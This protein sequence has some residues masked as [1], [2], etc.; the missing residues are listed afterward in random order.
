MKADKKNTVILVLLAL[1][2]T[3]TIVLAGIFFFRPNTGTA[4]GGRIPFTSAANGKYVLYIGTNDKDTYAQ[5]IPTDKAK[6]IVNRICVK[7]IGGYTAQDAKG[8]W[9]DETGKLTQE[10]TLV[11]SLNGV[12]E[13]QVISIMND[14]LKALNQDSILV[15]VQNV[16]YAYYKGGK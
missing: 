13:N 11:Y 14:V 4:P 15:E 9:V 1:N 12:S 5:K 2:I 6:D 16:D 7:Y 8:G 10:N 3:A